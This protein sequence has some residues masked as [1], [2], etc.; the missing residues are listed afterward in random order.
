MEFT[1]RS[2]KSRIIC[3]DMTKERNLLRSFLCSWNGFKN[4]RCLHVSRQ[5][6][7]NQTALFKAQHHQRVIHKLH[8]RERIKNEKIHFRVE[9]KIFNYCIKR[10]LTVSNSDSSV[11]KKIASA[12]WGQT[13]ESCSDESIFDW[14]WLRHGRRDISIRD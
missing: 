4:L 8:R 7:I 12:D 1:I 3:S 10:I 9:E 5:V 13:D 14:M 2:L 6:V 11:W